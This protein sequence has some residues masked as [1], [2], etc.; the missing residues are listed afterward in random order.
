M[1]MW[2]AFLVS[3]SSWDFKV[4][5]IIHSEL[6]YL[7]LWMKLRV[8]GKSFSYPIGYGCEGNLSEAFLHIAPEPSRPL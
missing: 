4:C 6:E 5:I 1:K 3:A 2:A 8:G 7:L